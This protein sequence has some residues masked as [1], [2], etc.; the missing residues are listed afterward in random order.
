MT[1]RFEMNDLKYAGYSIISKL[2]AMKTKLW[3]ALFF[4]GKS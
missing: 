2:L 1:Y 4:S 3:K